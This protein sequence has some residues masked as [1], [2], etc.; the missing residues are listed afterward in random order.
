M[1]SAIDIAIYIIW[2]CK[3]HGYTISNLKLQKI[4]YF[5]QAEFL[6]SAGAPCFYQ[7]I[8]AWDFGPVIPEVYHEFKIYGSSG[9]PK[10][11]GNN[12]NILILNR[13]KKM[14]NEIVD[15]CA[16]YSASYLVE[17]THN[18]D[19]WNDAYERYCNN[20]ISNDSIK[21]YFEKE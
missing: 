19:P 11:E 18:Q 16:N 13:D 15:E 6:V 12:S 8:E 20:V 9:I 10:S 17:I 1:Y 7:D 4:L 5:V 21:E 3:N 2:Y 14:I